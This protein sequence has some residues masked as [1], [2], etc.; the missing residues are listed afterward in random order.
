MAATRVL[1]MCLRV[2]VT[3]VTVTVLAMAVFSDGPGFSVAACPFLQSAAHRELP[4]SA[5]WIVSVAAAAGA[6]ICMAPKLSGA[7][8]SRKRKKP[9]LGS[10]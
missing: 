10:I 3:Q 4:V 8:S 9:G 6:M 5:S 7:V 1:V 2:A